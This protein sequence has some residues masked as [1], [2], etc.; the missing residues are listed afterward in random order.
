[1]WLGR[2]RFLIITFLVVVVVAI[3][4][5]TA[6]QLDLRTI[7]PLI[8]L[9][10]TLAVFCLIL[11]RWLP[12]AKWQAPLQMILDVLIITGVVYATGSQDSEFISLYLL[13]ILMGSLLFSGRGAFLMAG[14]SFVL[15]ALI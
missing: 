12:Q 10:Y 2:V 3:R 14:G 15:L 7:I 1:P 8:G 13:A 9:W 5:L 11:Q 4:Q 6:V